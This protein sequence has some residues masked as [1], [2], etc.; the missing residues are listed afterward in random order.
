MVTPETGPH[1]E[2]EPVGTQLLDLLFGL[3]PLNFQKDHLLEDP[4]RLP[5]KQHQ[6]FLRQGL[7][8]W[9]IRQVLLSLAA[10]A[11]SVSIG[12]VLQRLGGQQAMALTAADRTV[13]SKTSIRTHRGVQETAPA[14]RLS[15]FLI[16]IGIPKIL[17]L[18][19]FFSTRANC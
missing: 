9:R 16:G 18:M 19:C 10:P 17:W 12:K 13:D 8:L 11:S 7:T 6:A 2:Q 5:Q 4:G 3:F 1:H 15:I 14:L